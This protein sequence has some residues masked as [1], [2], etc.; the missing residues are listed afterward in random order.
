[1]RSMSSRERGFTLIEVL[2]AMAIFAIGS[3]GV[4]AM[5]TTSLQEN[6][7]ARQAHEATLLASMKLEHLDNV[8]GSDADLTSCSSRCW[9]DSSMVTQTSSRTIQMENVGGGSATS[10]R[11]QL[12][13]SVM[14]PSNL[15]GGK[16]YTVTVFWP[17]DKTKYGIAYN[18]TGY[19]DCT[20]SPAQCHRVDFYGMRR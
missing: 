11:Y 3:L 16:A 9:E 6:A 15:A 14:T 7:S 17:R 13:W 5:M 12:T 19:V 2:I 8:A 18:A 1:M 10:T 20:V 4:L